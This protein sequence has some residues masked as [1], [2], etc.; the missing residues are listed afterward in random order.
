MTWS[1]ILPSLFLA[2]VAVTA[3]GCAGGICV[4]HAAAVDAVREKSIGCPKLSSNW[5]DYVP[6]EVVAAC[7]EAAARHCTPSDEDLMRAFADCIDKIAACDGGDEQAE[8]FRDKENECVK[9]LD[10]ISDTCK[11]VF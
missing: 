5:D 8:A 3:S 7:S 2:G 11:R 9:G 6:N 4:D 1:R 10:G